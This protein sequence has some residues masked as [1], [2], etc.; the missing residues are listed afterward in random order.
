[1]AAKGVNKEAVF[2]SFKAA[3]LQAH[4]E[5]ELEADGFVVKGFLDATLTRYLEAR[6][7]VEKDSVKMLEDTLAWRKQ[8]DVAS[9]LDR[10]L[11]QEK[12]NALRKFHPQGEHGVDRE[13]NILYVERIGYLDAEA[14]MKNVTMEDAVLYHIQKYELQ[15][16]VTF[17]QAS[18]EQKRIVNK[19]TVIYD[20]E[21][22]GMQTFKKVVFDFI[23]Q[24]SAIGQD[25]YP[26][27]LNRV[28]VVNAPFFFFTTWKIIEVFLNPTTRKKI[29]FL[30][31]GFKKELVKH[32]DP[33]QLPKW[34]GGTCECIPAKP[35]G[36]CISCVEN[37]QTKACNAMDEY[38]AARQLAKALPTAPLAAP[39][40]VAPLPPGITVP[41]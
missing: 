26:D 32:I 30:G 16:H 23:K 21:N 5:A 17:A 27:T 18:V 1:M 24:T 10:P 25:H 11:P 20:L 31:S 37:T 35:H 34:L 7:Y 36:G 3:V 28:F 12:M 29:Q 6:N 14:L 19:M 2:A 39:A 38:L 40:P 4:P 8:N 15:H 13:G 33:S 41:Q 9:V 22:I